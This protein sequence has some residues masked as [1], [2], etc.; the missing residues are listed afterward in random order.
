VISPESCSTILLGDPSRGAD[1]AEALRITAPELLRLGVV[2]GVVPEPP[3]GADAAPG[4]M[5]ASLGQAL[6]AELASL[7]GL[8][9]ER[10]RMDR[11]LRFRRLGVVCDG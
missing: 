4:T 9:G 5:A 6:L 11:H 1:M 8:S 10:L 3:G 7:R 2:D